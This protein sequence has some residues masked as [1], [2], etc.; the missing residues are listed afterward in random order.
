MKLRY[1]SNF[2][3]PLLA[4]FAT[5]LRAD[6]VINEILHD[7]EPNTACDEFIELHNSGPDAVALSDW[8]FSDGVDYTFPAG[9]MLDAGGYLVI[10]QDP[11][12]LAAIYGVSALGPW[13]GGLRNEG[14]TIS[15]RNAAGVLIDEVSYRDAFPWPLGALGSGR[16][17]ELINPSLDNDLGSSW[18]ATQPPPVL[19]ELA[20]FPEAGNWSYRKGTSEPPADWNTPGFVE[21]AEWLD[22][23]TPIGFGNA[24]QTLKTTLTDMRGNYPSVYARHAFTVAAGEIPQALRLR[25]NVDDGFIAFINGT[26]VVRIRADGAGNFDDAASASQPSE[27]TWAELDLAAGAVVEGDNVLAIIN[28]NL[29]VSGSDFAFDFEL[30]RPAIAEPEPVP[31]PGKLNSVFAANAAPN[32]RQV[33]HFPKQP[34]TGDA[35]VITAKVTDADGVAAVSLEYQVVM[36]GAYIPALLAKPHSVLLSDPNGP[37]GPNPEYSNPANWT[38]VAMVDDGTGGDAVAGDDIYSATVPV[39]VNRA[40][41]RYRITVADTPGASVRV[42]YE[43]DPSL[44]FAYYVYNGVPD[45]VADTRSV[46]GQV[47]YT[48][49]KE[50]LTSLPVYAMLTTQADFDQCVA[51]SGTTIPSNNFDARSAFNWGATFVYD[52]V[53]YDNIAYRLRQRN[54]RY[55]GGG[56]RSSA[57]GGGRNG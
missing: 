50:V 25:H 29:P 57:G 26:E 38:T 56:K 35:A 14:E 41:V 10:A 4:V 6:I 8:F 17:M 18:R 54:D 3:I 5:S 23:Q 36:P 12:S 42:P 28:Y 15:L 21:G 16:S 51:Y 13:V 20:Y 19:G 43:D 24:G 34:T 44:N 33:N 45:F 46:T 30:I 11:D 49:P 39:Q 32:I 1:A 9:T 7:S 37:R 2:L 27:G 40:L 22:G 47:P 31:T 48:H 53:V 55:G 52:G